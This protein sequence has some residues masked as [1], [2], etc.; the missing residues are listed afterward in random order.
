MKEVAIMVDHR[1]H[2]HAR[3]H[4]SIWEPQSVI[5]Q[6]RT[7]FCI[8]CGKKHQRISCSTNSASKRHREQISY[9]YQFLLFKLS[10]VRFLLVHQKATTLRGAPMDGKLASE[11]RT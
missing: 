5:N 4:K 9:Q 6:E 7:A 10:I 2:P 1:L 3:A 11:V 8:K